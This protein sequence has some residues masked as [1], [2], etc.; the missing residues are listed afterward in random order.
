MTVID[1]EEDP[2]ATPPEGSKVSHLLL[3]LDW[4]KKVESPAL[5]VVRINFNRVYLE[6]I[7]TTIGSAGKGGEVAFCKAKRLFQISM[8]HLV[9]PM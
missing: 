5:E 6:H 9:M 8:K 1:A 2:I 7:I 4:L 3:I